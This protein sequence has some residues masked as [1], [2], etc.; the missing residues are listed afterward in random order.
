LSPARRVAGERLLVPVD[1]FHAS[2]ALVRGLAAAGY[3]PVTAISHRQT[4][5]A[6]SRAS[7]EVVEVPSAEGS[8]KE[9]AQAVIALAPQLG[10]SAV[11]PGTEAALLALAR[12]AGSIPVPFGAPVREIVER[13]TDKARVIALAPACGLS[14]P[15]TVVDTPAALIARAADF[16]YPVILKPERTRIAVEDRLAYFT[17]CRIASARQLSDVL[18]TRPSAQWAVQPYLPG[19]LA[20]VSGV[21]WEGRVLA[22]LHQRSLRIWPPEAGYSCYAISTEADHELEERIGA[23][24]GRLGWSGIFQVQMLQSGHGS[25]RVIDFN[26]RPYGSLALAIRA[27]L[28]LPGIWADLV[29]GRVPVLPRPRPGVRYR[30]ESGDAKAIL[31]ALRQRRLKAAAAAALP[32]RDTAHAVLSLRDPAPAVV[33]AGK[34]LARTRR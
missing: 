33:L 27:G 22:T 13:A 21:A 34:L 11:L 6:R 4:F 15:R 17:A 29:L 20:A 7:S 1:E 26:P 28:N 16:D 23:L 31:R 19:N 5:A 25:P 32:R 9:F 10:V 2:L 3:A 18:E 14:V 24:V 12:Y 30:L 8:P